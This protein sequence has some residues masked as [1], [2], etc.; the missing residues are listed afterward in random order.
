[1][2]VLEMSKNIVLINGSPRKKTTYNYLLKLANL[3]QSKGFTT[4]IVSLGELNITPCTGCEVC[5]IKGKCIHKDGVEELRNEMKRADGIVI[6]SPV[7]LRGIS[8]LLKNFIDRTCEYYH[9]TDIEGKPVLSI[10]TTAASGLKETLTY[11]EDVV[12]QWG[13]IPCGSISRSLRNNKEITESEIEKF[14]SYINNGT[15]S[16]RPSLKLLMGFQV[17]KILAKKIIPL[18]KTYWEQKGWMESYYFFPCK[19]SLYK[20][21][22]A[23]VFFKIL[24]N[25]IRLC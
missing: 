20:R 7:Y 25:R 10:A 18:D 24:N 16:Y 14:L 17:Q 4:K 23:N 12:V 19:I 22:L 21:I 3:L 8:G 6:A 13:A 1:M 5:I 11:M 2:G 9:R 15:D